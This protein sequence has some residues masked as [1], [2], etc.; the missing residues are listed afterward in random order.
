MLRHLL[1]KFSVWYLSSMSLGFLLTSKFRSSS[2][3]QGSNSIAQSLVLV[4]EMIL[5]WTR[6]KN[7]HNL[8]MRTTALESQSKKGREILQHF[9]WIRQRDW[10]RKGA[11]RETANVNIFFLCIANVNIRPA[12]IK[13]LVCDGTTPSALTDCWSS[14]PSVLVEVVYH[15]TETNKNLRHNEEHTCS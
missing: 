13:Y 11:G 9:H 10:E 8:R 1:E 12:K 15:E 7:N 2:F 14:L 3:E 4:T 5:R 6:D